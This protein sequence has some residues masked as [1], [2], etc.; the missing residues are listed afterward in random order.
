VGD[1]LRVAARR[2]PLLLLLLAQ[3]DAGDDEGPLAPDAAD[4]VPPE[5]EG[6]HAA[7]RE[8]Q[9]VAVDALRR[10]DCR[11]RQ[12]EQRRGEGFPE[13]VHGAS[14]GGAKKWGV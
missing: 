6:P 4:L 2:G 5:R 10:R 9:V 14:H 3:A 1:G 12:E 8:R 11:E 13:G 7:L